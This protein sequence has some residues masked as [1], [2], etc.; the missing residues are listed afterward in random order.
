MKSLAAILLFALLPAVAYAQQP[1]PT[2]ESALKTIKDMTSH[3]KR[4]FREYYGAYSVLRQTHATYT[5]DELD[6]FARELEQIIRD[7]KEPQASE[8]A[9]ALMFSSIPEGE[10]TPYANAASV[11]IRIYE[12]YRDVPALQREARHVLLRVYLAEGQEYVRNLFQT[13]ERPQKPCFDSHVGWPAEVEFPPKEEWCDTVRFQS[14]WCRA[15]HVLLSQGYRPPEISPLTPI[16]R[17]CGPYRGIR[18]V[19]DES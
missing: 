6:A 1:T 12:S 16:A 9:R 7:G 14:D 13:S 11:F 10:G 5:N 8:A 2:P 4:S 3:T 15:A 19:Y 17:Y 18:Y